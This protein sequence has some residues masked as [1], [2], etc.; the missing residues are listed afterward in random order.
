MLVLES[1]EES[2]AVGL[3]ILRREMG[4]PL[5]GD[6]G[7][8]LILADLATPYSWPSLAAPVNGAAVLDLAEVGDGSVVL[9]GTGVTYAGGGWDFNGLTGGDCFVQSPAGCLSSI[10][11]G[12]QYFMVTTWAKLPAEADW[13][14]ALPI[15][16]LFQTAVTDNTAGP[17]MLTLNLAA[18][19]RVE[20]RRQTALGT[21]VNTFV[22]AD[23]AIWGQVCQIAFWRN[24]AGVGLRV[25]SAIGQKQAVG[26]VGVN[27]VANF[28]LTRAQ[29]GSPPA[30]GSFIKGRFY[31]FGVENLE[32]SGRDPGT[33]LNTDFAYVTGQAVFS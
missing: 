29:A 13:P 20:A 24:A 21:V 9:T 14:T 6:G 26:A 2:D 16:T 5:E 11:A 12:A 15:Q 32:T 27:N 25:R 18:G 30:F 31:R 10:W 19:N 28:G 23:A 17:D 3:D 4:G 33:V 22:F 1:S 8:T 7:G